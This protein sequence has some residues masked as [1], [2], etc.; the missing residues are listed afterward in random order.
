MPRLGKVEY[1]LVTLALLGIS[2][3]FLTPFA[4]SLIMSV[5]TPAELNTTDIWALPQSPTIANYQEM[6]ANPNVD[7]MQLLQNTILIATFS[8]L[9][10]VVSSAMVAYA[11]ARLKFIGR[12]KLFIILLSTMMLPGVVTM[13]P[14]YVIFKHLHWVN[15]FLPLTVPAFLGGGA[16]NIFLMRQFLKSIP[17]DLDE[18]AKLDGASHWLIFWRILMPLSGPALA[19]VGVFTFIG[20]WRDFLGPLLYL[21]DVEKQTLELGLNTYTSMQ[22][23]APWHLIMAGSVLVMLPLIVIFIFGQRYFVKGI[24]MTGIK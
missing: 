7:F 12:D 23:T 2:A 8:T 3:A 16:F 11:F 22:T 6:L 21:N 17:M 9:G 5:K 13:I 4:V 18:A 14:T 1:W 20:A 15:T 24:T 19:T 10:A